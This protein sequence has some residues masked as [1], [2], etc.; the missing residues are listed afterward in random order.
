MTR[1]A[2]CS[3]DRATNAPHAVSLLA[4]ETV[5]SAFDRLSGEIYPT[6]N[7][8]IQMESV[9]LRDAIGNR[10]GH[11]DIGADT[12]LSHAAM[13]TRPATAALDPERASVLW[14]QGYG[15]LGDVS[16]NAAALS[17]SV[18]GYFGGVD[19]VVAVSIVRPD[20]G[21]TEGD[22][23]PGYI[24]RYPFIGM[25]QGQGGNLL[26]GLDLSAAPVSTDAARDGARPLFSDDGSATE[27]ARSAM[28]LCEAYA[29]EH[30]RTRAFGDAL[31][32]ANLL[33]ARE[34]RVTLP[35]GEEKLI[36]G[37]RLID[38]AAF[39]ALSGPTLETFHARGW[40]DLVIL[41]LA[42]LHAWRILAAR[43]FP[44]G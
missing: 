30:D 2:G 41:H 20:G 11:S 24:R 26:L 15:A 40:T 21:C 13:A 12:A 31:E 29:A 1:H 8:M 17:S 43:A 28:A 33:A 39:R 34:A 10:I 16:G 18:G 9:H 7:T 22:Y 5:P 6:V 36:Q 25:T 4:Q 42:S 3:Q 32:A 27:T 37:F 38:E 23:V 14:A 19:T 44:A 35:G